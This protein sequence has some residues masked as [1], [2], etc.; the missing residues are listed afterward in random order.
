MGLGTGEKRGI[1]PRKTYWGSY[2]V[3][4]RA[5][6]DATVDW[7]SGELRGRANDRSPRT[8]RPSFNSQIPSALWHGQ[9]GRARTPPDRFGWGCGL[10]QWALA[11]PANVTFGRCARAK[12]LNECEKTTQ[13]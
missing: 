10:L 3:D 5:S 8:R 6:P 7:L 11:R 2:W 4:I 12:V 9:P 1:L 13:D